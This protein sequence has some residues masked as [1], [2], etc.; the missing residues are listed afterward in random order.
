M[1]FNSWPATKQ[2]APALAT[3]ETLAKAACETIRPNF[4]YKAI[5]FNVAGTADVIDAA[6]TLIKVIAPAGSVYPVQNCGIKTGGNT[7][8]AQGEFVLLYD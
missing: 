2:V 3:S 4:R 5:W 8:V 1:Q 6:G 7:T